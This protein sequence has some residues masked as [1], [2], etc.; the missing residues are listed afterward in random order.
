MFRPVIK[1]S[2][3]VLFAAMLT[4]PV[5]LATAAAADADQPLSWSADGKSSMSLE[6]E[7]RIL[8]MTDNVQL[9]QGSLHIS[10]DSARFEYHAAT[11]ILQKVLVRGSPVRYR[12]QLAEKGADGADDASGAGDTG[13]ANDTD[14][15]GSANAADESE[16]S[17]SGTA[18]EL[19]YD[20]E[21]GE[22]L[23]E[24][25]GSADIAASIQSPGTS[26]SCVAIIYVVESDLVR[27]ATGP[28]SG[29]LS[30]GNQSDDQADN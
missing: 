7:T 30:S 10:G 6:G 24:L 22:T 16:V 9:I 23:I 15:A 4:T 27:E 11:N 17:G 29:A 5:A 1:T 2:H 25:T 3:I 20:S 13:T 19:Y 21:S 14:G 12:Q 8:E 18:L 26:I 28:C